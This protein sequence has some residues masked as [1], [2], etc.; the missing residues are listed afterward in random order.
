MKV[1]G[2]LVSAVVV[3]VAAATLAACGASSAGAATQLEPSSNTGADPFTNS[4]AIG[5]A[6][7]FP[8]NVQAI[9]AST[10]KTFATDPKTKTLAATGTAP[11][12]Y[13]GTGNA[14]TCDATQLV[15]FLQQNPAKG[16][17][18]A[19]V[20]GIAPADIGKY[21]ATLTP[22]I[23]TSDTL[24]TNH[25]YA[26][27]HAT[28]L[29]SVLQAGTAVMIDNTGVP[30]AKCNCG[31]PLT[32]AEPSPIGKTQ[33]AAWPGYT[34]TQ[35]VVVNAGSSTQNFTLIN[36]T[37]GDTYTQPA[38]SGGNQQWVVTQIANPSAAD[39]TT[40]AV[41]PDGRKWSNVTTLP[42][43][44]FDALAYG[45]G[46]WV[47]VTRT[48]A[49][50]ELGIDTSTDLKNW[51]RTFS[52]PSLLTGVAYGNGHWVAVGETSATNP[53]GVVYTST[54]AQHWTESYSTPAGSGT[55]FAAVTFGAD[56][57]IAFQQGQ[58]GQSAVNE[59]TSTDGT[60]WSNWTPRA[61]EGDITQNAAFG[62]TQWARTAYT[63]Q[64][65]GTPFV[66]VSPD[67]KTW[68]VVPNSPQAAA[69]GFGNGMFMAVDN[70][71]PHPEE[72]DDGPVVAQ[73][74][75]SRD[76]KTWTPAGSLHLQTTAIVYGPVPTNTKTT[77]APTPTTTPAAP[78]TTTPPATTPV[79]SPPANNGAVQSFD[80]KNYT[81][82]DFFSCQGG[83]NVKY[84]NGE[85]HGT[86]E[87]QNCGEVI[88]GVDFADVTG[89]GQLD[90]IIN[91]TGSQG[92]TALGA[93]S[94]TGVFTMSSGRPVNVAYLDGAS[95]PPYPG[96][97]TTW[98]PAPGP[99]DYD[100]CPSNFTKTTYTYS[101]GSRS[102]VKASTST[103]PA[104]QEPKR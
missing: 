48:Q 45:N 9:T 14:Q 28:T 69:I 92:G 23:L 37:T 90:A 82:K 54:D 77:P 99:N 91:F 16:S 27:G 24:V 46:T 60:H 76:A 85:V 72:D 6:A 7:A 94:Y 21:V 15:T 58:T 93:A 61:V 68:T 40:I 95:F 25:G 74:S 84:T 67:A 12:L 38:G 39:E 41:S 75:T 10:R 100:C 53:T 96:S 65:N 5:P 2:L 49:G 88:S 64:G 80:W 71:H 20:E 59:M 56:R 97:I 36:V 4:V 34:S 101:S 47:A 17:A 35:V 1:R 98:V 32:P 42:N 33:G 44:Q 26:N 73:F 29:Q 11:G 55:I 8:S 102:F 57:F 62:N 51:H 103:V 81:Y 3:F 89:D 22:I 79:T 13:G 30:R 19:G 66:S 78:A 70:T 63:T 43:D 104:S 52:A 83:G 31:N 87:L 50:E 86:G 18:W